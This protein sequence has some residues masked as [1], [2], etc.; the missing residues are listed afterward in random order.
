MRFDTPIYFIKEVRGEYDPSTGDYDKPTLT[1]TLRFASANDTQS[2]ALKL[3]YGSI[4]EGSLIARLQTKYEEPFDY[5]RIGEKH[6]KV[7]RERRLRTKHT[8]ILVEVK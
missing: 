8:F 2:E 5:I 1:E 7:V 3:L 6:Y 4:P